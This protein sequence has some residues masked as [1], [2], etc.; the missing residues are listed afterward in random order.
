LLATGGQGAVSSPTIGGAGTIVL[1]QYATGDGKTVVR[2]D[3]Q[4]LVSAT[5]PLSTSTP[6][7]V[8]YIP[9]WPS[10]DMTVRARG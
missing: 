1:L 10:T 3:A 7:A 6:V 8:T 5:L 4:L 2:R 9:A